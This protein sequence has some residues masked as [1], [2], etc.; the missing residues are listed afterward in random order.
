MR[1]VILAHLQTKRPEELQ[2]R[3]DREQ[4]KSELKDK[5][6]ILISTGQQDPDAPLIEEVH[7]Q[8]LVVG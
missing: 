1:D 2:S 5:L 6:N 7:I 3:A 8:K 4:L